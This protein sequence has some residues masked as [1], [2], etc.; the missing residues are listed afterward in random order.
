MSDEDLKLKI[1]E[2]TE[3]DK[4]IMLSR[5]KPLTTE[6]LTGFG[7]VKRRFPSTYP[8]VKFAMP[9]KEDGPKGVSV[10]VGVKGTF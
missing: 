3:L 7:K 5:S 2:P 1:G 4:A 9:D 6:E 8:F 10:T